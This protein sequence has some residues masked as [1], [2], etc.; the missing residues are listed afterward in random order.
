M[1]ER[2]TMKLRHPLSLAGMTPSNEL[3]FEVR[4]RD[5]DLKNLRPQLNAR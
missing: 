5:R 3:F 4:R 2:K 1:K